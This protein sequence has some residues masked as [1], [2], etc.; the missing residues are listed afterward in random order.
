M[1]L[2]GIADELFCLCWLWHQLYQPEQWGLFHLL[3]PLPLL[4]LLPMARG[5]PWREMLWEVMITKPS[6]FSSLESLCFVCSWIG[7]CQAAL[8]AWI[9]G[10]SVRTYLLS[11]RKTKTTAVLVGCYTADDTALA[12]HVNVPRWDC[13]RCRRTLC[14]WAECCCYRSVKCPCAVIWTG[15][16]SLLSEGVAPG[17]HVLFYSTAAAG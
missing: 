2:S 1:N 5:V 4:L 15:C 11:Q 8:T 14:S 12:W 3:S 9:S 7:C 10:T 16:W 13:V 17:C 6:S